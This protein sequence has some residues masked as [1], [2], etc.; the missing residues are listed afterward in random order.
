[1]IM[2]EGNAYKP[3]WQEGTKMRAEVLMGCRVQAAICQ[4]AVS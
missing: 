2:L 3:C 1:M 4:H